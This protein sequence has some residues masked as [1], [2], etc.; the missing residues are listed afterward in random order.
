M[1]QECIICMETASRTQP[2]TTI[3]HEGKGC[4]VHIH[5]TCWQKWNNTHPNTCSLCRELLIPPEPEVPDMETSHDQI[6]IIVLDP[7]ILQQPQ[8][9]SQP[10]RPFVQPRRRIIQRRGASILSYLCVFGC[11]IFVLVLFAPEMFGKK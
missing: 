4:I 7:S 5:E 11:F 10:Q 6:Q 9:Q 1:E 2:I 8:P 3:V